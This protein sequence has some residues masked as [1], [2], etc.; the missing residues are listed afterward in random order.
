MALASAPAA[1]NGRFPASNQI[2][3]SPRD[4]HLVVTRT[5]YG[6]LPSYDDGASWSLLCEDALGLP[7]NAYEDP[8][9]AF[10]PGGSLVAGLSSPAG[11][12]DVSMDTGCNWSCVG[13]ALAGQSIADVVVRYAAPSAVL[14]LTSTYQPL[15]AGGGTFSQVFESADDGVTWRALGEPIDPEILVQTID[16]AESDPQRL[17]VSGTRGFGP[18]RTASLLVSA[19]DGAQWTER[20]IPSFDPTL[21]DSVYVGAV[22]PADADRVY[23]RS[24]ALPT[25]GESR[26]YVTSSAGQ[27]FETAAR[28]AVPTPSIVSNAQILGFA[29]SPDGSKIYV[30]TQDEGLFVAAKT[31][32]VFRQTSSIHVQCLA[33]R[34]AE[35][36]ACSDAVS[37]F[38]VGVSTDDGATFEPRL[39]TVT[40]LAGPVACAAD[41]GGSL[42]CG[43]TANASQCTSAFQAVCQYSLTGRCDGPD[44]RDTGPPDATPPHSPLMARSGGCST[45]GSDSGPALVACGALVAAAAI[46]RRRRID[47]GAE[48]LRPRKDRHHSDLPP[49]RPEER[50]ACRP[51]G[52]RACASPGLLP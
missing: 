11:G 7:Q 41:S 40:D 4:S 43:A 50:G 2:L 31:D 6:I 26:L 30:G 12:L 18:N 34:A 36:W 49:A 10:T 37:G 5:T 51:A 32:L 38:V 15:D 25:G 14:A 33:T 24:S 13:D 28:F 45:S 39:A 16:V 23:V 48:A 22:D 42:A 27:S 9:L 35:L 17:Y 29:L 3:F 47:K 52:L 46:R 20:P 1:A 8:E 21:E 44:D 19:D